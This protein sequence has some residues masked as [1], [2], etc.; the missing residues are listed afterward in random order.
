MPRRKWSKTTHRTIANL[1]YAAGCG[2]VWTLDTEEIGRVLMDLKRLNALEAGVQECTPH[3]C[4]KLDRCYL[5]EQ[6]R[7]H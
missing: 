7:A 3:H 2:G 6:R 4:R 5:L 1:E